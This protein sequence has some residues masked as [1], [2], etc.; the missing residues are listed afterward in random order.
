MAELLAVAERLRR[1]EARAF[2]GV[3][4]LALVGPGHGLADAHRV[5]SGEKLKSATST[6][7]LFAFP[8]D[9][10]QPAAAAPSASAAS[11]AASCGPSRP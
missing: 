7:P 3:L 6:D 4:H 8:P 5:V 1:E 10:P 11:A 2:D 9:D